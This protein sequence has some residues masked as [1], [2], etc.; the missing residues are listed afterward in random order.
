MTFAVRD[1]SKQL[2][3][4]DLDDLRPL[5]YYCAMTERN[6]CAEQ[7]HVPTGGNQVRRP[8]DQ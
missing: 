1:D 4:P 2:L 7:E 3:L 8:L 6:D 5:W